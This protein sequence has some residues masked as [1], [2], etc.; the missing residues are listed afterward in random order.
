MRMNNVIIA[1]IGNGEEKIHIYHISKVSV[2]TSTFLSKLASHHVIS[3]VR[4]CHQS[5]QVNISPC[6]FKRTV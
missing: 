5:S 1:S 6:S 3:K 4:M 2:N